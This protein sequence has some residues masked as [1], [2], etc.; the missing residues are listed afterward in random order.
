[1]DDQI[2]QKD[3]LITEYPL[4]LGNNRSVCGKFN[5]GIVAYGLLVDRI[6]SLPATD[7]KNALDASALSVMT[8][9]TIAI[10]SAIGSS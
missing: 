8:F 9:C 2:A 6:G 5:V 7:I 3:I 4:N 10:A 1:M